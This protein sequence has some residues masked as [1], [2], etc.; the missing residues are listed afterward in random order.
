MKFASWSSTIRNHLLEVLLETIRCQE[1][2][3]VV[4]CEKCLLFFT[5]AASHLTLLMKTH[6]LDAIQNVCFHLFLKV[7]SK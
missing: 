3:D 5:G 2:D 6:D 1:N 4:L 7:C